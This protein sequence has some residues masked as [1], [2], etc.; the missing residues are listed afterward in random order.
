MIDCG[1]LNLALLVIQL[2][3]NKPIF[4]VYKGIWTNRHHNQVTY[5]TINIET[6]QYSDHSRVISYG[7]LCPSAATSRRDKFKTKTVNFAPIDTS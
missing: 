3:L 1:I 4:T 6:M 5:N 7:S 2:H